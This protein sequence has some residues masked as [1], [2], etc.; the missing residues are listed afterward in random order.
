MN[1]ILIFPPMA[2]ATQPYSS[3]PAL[4][5][6]LRHRGWNQVEQM[7]VNIEFVT[8]LLNGKRME[9]IAERIGRRLARLDRRAALK[10]DGVEYALLVKA[11][12]KAPF[13]ISG[14]D[15]AVRELREPGCFRDLQRLNDS[16]RLVHEAFEMLSAT[17]FPLL[18]GFSNTTGPPLDTTTELMHWA[19]ESTRNPYI[20]F[21]EEDTLPKLSRKAPGAIGISITYRAQVLAAATLALLV[22]KHLPG[23]PVILGGNIVSCWYDGLE[24]CPELFDWCDY[25]IPFEGESAL[26]RLLNSLYGEKSL[27]HVPNLVYRSGDVIR[28]NPVVLEEIDSLPTP[29]YRGLP[30]DQYLAPEPVLLLSASRGCYW[31]RCHFCSVSASMRPGYRARDVDLVH[32]DIVRL[33]ERHNARCFA[34][35]DDCVVPAFL[36]KFADR[37]NRKGPEVYWQCEVRFEEALTERLLKEMRDAGCLNLIFGLESYSSRVLSL[38]NKGIERRQID[39]I[40]RD[41]RKLGIAF[42]LQFFFGF[43]GEKPADAGTTTAFIA[44]ELHG[45]ATFS[46]GTFEVQR[47]SAVEKDPAAFG[48]GNVDHT[49]GPLAV[50]YTYSPVPSHAQKARDELKEKLRRIIKYPY[51]GLSINAHTLI[52]LRESGVPAMAGLYGPDDGKRMSSTGAV[53]DLME[54]RLIRQA[55][56]SVGTFRHHAADALPASP[57]YTGKQR[58][59]AMLY[60]Y[61]HD[62]IVEVSPLVLWILQ[63]LDGTARPSDLVNALVRELASEKEESVRVEHLAPI[64]RSALEELVEKHF[65]APLRA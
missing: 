26:D 63:H 47:G 36:R 64:V 4:A 33:R 60:D 19:Q 54:E 23:V 18:F 41:S 15:A 45:A 17:T 61:T 50:K 31:S 46:F 7:D 59:H 44:K 6:F 25:L 12:L 5:G 40:I 8:H 11:A 20:R 30:L 13:V 58:E 49:C 39:R 51:P 37:L 9:Q 52:F 14:I 55:R 35:S 27:A 53:P 2:D 32:E 43:P 24:R 21:F 34:F 62:S 16:R 42:N 38:M 22:K 29:D 10:E 1:I 57:E 65:I 48:L 56:Q 28:K 3:L